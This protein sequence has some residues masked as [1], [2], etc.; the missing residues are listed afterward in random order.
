MGKERNDR[1][2]FYIQTDFWEAVEDM[3]PAQQDKYFGALVRLFFTGEDKPPKSATKGAYINARGRVMS[4]RNRSNRLAPEEDEDPDNEPPNYHAPI[5]EGEGDS[6][7]SVGSESVST[8]DIQPVS[9]PQ[10]DTDPSESAKF[11]GDALVIFSEITKRPCLIPGGMV[12]GYLQQIHAAGYT[13]DDVRSVC[14][15]QQR[16]WQNDRK[17]QRNIRPLTLFEPSKFESYLAA[18]KNDPE[19]KIDAEAAKYAGAF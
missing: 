14:S 1:G 6:S 4:A 17:M 15:Y 18:A 2:G 5:K 11:V 7:I 8:V 13:L 9:I 19:V 10:V 12:V 16:E 3:T